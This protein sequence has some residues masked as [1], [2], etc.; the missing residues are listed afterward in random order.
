MYKQ[1]VIDRGLRAKN[2]VADGS[3]L[4][5]VFEQAL[6]ENYAAYLASAYDEY[7]LRDRL[8]SDMRGL[9]NVKR[10]I[11]AHIDNGVVESRLKAEEEEGRNGP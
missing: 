8:Y 11:S 5:E 7:D 2:A 3:Y 10:I 6:Q 1:D 4:A 9:N